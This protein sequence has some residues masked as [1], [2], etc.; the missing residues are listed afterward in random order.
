MSSVPRLIT[1]AFALV[2]TA[3]AQVY[4]FPGYPGYPEL[5]ITV[6]GTSPFSLDVSSGSQTVYNSA[7]L[8]GSS[9]NSAKAVSASSSGKIT[10]N[11]GQISAMLVN[12]NV[13]KVSVNTTSDFVGARF[14]TSSDKNFYGV[15]EYPWN[16]IQLT[17]ANVSFDLK[18]L[19]DSDGVNWDN[20]RAP[21][22]FTDAG[23]GVYTDTMDMGSYDFMTPGEVN[24]V[25]NTSSLVYYIILPKT[26]G[27]YKSI[28]TEYTAL[29]ASIEMPPDSGFGPT[30]WVSLI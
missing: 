24:F 25:F 17:N 27:D 4:D 20:A 30:F 5:S 8:A 11:G 10:D 2:T 28:L 29:S 12:P 23:Y 9:N 7:I 14:T 18:G 16:N 6:S 3:A 26:P 15:W 1:S 21:F 22:F 13:A 19:G